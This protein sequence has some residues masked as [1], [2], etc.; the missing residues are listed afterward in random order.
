MCKNNVMNLVVVKLGRFSISGN[1]RNSGLELGMGPPGSDLL[2]ISGI[3]LN[4]TS[5]SIQT[6]TK[7]ILLS[8]QSTLEGKIYIRESQL[9][10][11]NEELSESSAEFTSPY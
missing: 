11:L 2:E 3:G 10:H 4:P 7:F 1:E 8:S 9:L 5:N 6:S